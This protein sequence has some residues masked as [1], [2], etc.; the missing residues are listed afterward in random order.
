MITAPIP[1]NEAERIATLRRFAI[2]DS[3]KESA[4]DRITDLASELFDAPIALISLIDTDRQWFKASCGLEAPELPRDLAFCAYTIL[5]DRV[6]CVPDTTQDDRFKENPFVTGEMGIKFYCGAPLIAQSGHRLGS[7]CVVDTKTR[8]DFTEKQQQRLAD[9]AAI[10][11]DQMDMRS[12]TGNVLEE[13]ECRQEAQDKAAATESQIRALIQHVPT[14]IA[15]MDMTGKY[16]ACSDSWRNF[17]ELLDADAASEGIGG[18]SVSHPVWHKAFNHA[19]TGKTTRIAEDPVKLANGE[20]EYLRWEARPWKSEQGEIKGV[21]ASS[22]R[23]TKQVEARKII[24]RQ[25]E[26]LNAVL[27][28]IKDGVVACDAEGSLTLFNQSGRVIHGVN[29]MPPHAEDYVESTNLFEADGITTLE[30]D[31]NPLFEAMK[32]KSVADREIVIAPSGLPKRHVIARAAPL[33]TSDD[34]LIGAVA[35]MTDVTSAKLAERQLRASEAHANYVAF[36]DTLTGLPNRAHFSRMVG[37]TKNSLQGETTAA[38]FLDLNQFKAVNDL[39]GHKVG[40]DLLKRTAKLLKR[41]VGRDAFASRLGGDEFIVFKPVEDEE[42]ALQLG[43]QMAHEIGQPLVIGGHTV[44][45][46]VSVGIALHPDH[47]NTHEDLMRRADLAMYKSKAAGNSE[48]VMYDPAFEL[49]TVKRRAMKLEL[50]KAIE[51]D[52]LEVYLQ[53]IVDA[54]TQVMIGAEA[55]ARWNHPS[56]GLILPTE[57]IPIAEESGFIVEL[58]DWVLRTAMEAMAPWSNL[59]LSVNLSPVQFKDP[60]LAERVFS[61]LDDTGFEPKRLE[62]EVTEGLLIYDTNVARRAIETFKTKGIQIALDDFGTGYS[63]LGYIQNF[64]F[65]KIKIDRSFVADIDKNPQSAAV[66][67][68]VVNLASSL[69][70]VVTAEGI[71]TERHEL[72]LKFI[73]CNTLQGFKYGRPLPVSEFGFPPSET[74][75]NV[76]AG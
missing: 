42:E 7:L 31:R 44:V 46:G 9:L 57:F 2:L 65:D 62:L 8:H 3:D 43:R 10:V 52:E 37:D 69:G 26:M 17:M 23:V 56:R 36:H 66:V 28:N 39:S 76:V 25:A 51:N 6:L 49:E 54:Q 55:L 50:A 34:T 15:L 18:L 14:G 40:D 12:V 24:E 73:G 16:L 41:I 11:V 1:A 33:K 30:N 72:L 68:C 38:F 4:F 21:I 61:A 75:R 19:L 48:P 45:S 22:M 70:I 13:I 63:S 59:F 5:E 35:S 67:Q 74:K 64:P 20:V 71:E 58:G 32:G 60:M 29:H 47:G 53:P 27:E